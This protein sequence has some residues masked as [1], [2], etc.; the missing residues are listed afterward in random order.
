MKDDEKKGYGLIDKDLEDLKLL[1]EMR[2]KKP[3]NDYQE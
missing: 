2:K 1:K 3:S